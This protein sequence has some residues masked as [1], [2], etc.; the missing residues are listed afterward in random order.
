MFGKYEGFEI[1]KGNRNDDYLYWIEFT[2]NDRVV[3]FI[4]NQDKF[5]LKIE[6]V[7]FKARGSELFEFVNVTFNIARLEEIKEKLEN[8]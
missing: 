1:T 2:K 5:Y 6:T 7:I 3:S 4:V 8:E